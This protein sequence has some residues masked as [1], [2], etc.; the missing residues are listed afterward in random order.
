MCGVV[1][2]P[3]FVGVLYPPRPDIIEIGAVVFTTIQDKSRD[4]YIQMM[5]IVKM[6]MDYDDSM[7]RM[8]IVVIM[9][10]K[11]IVMMMIVVI[12]IV[13][14]MMLL[15]MHEYKD[16]EWIYGI[17]SAWHQVGTSI[18][19][20]CHFERNSMTRSTL[21]VEHNDDDEEGDEDHI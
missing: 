9:I 12:M 14:M 17:V 21:P 15:V 3:V 6:I 19:Y 8:M 13:I 18:S 4:F 20:S 11:M 5:M 7:V 10:V 2:S 1:L 16:D